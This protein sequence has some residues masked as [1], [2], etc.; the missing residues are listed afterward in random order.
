M[1]TLINE[2]TCAKTPAYTKPLVSDL[3]KLADETK[4]APGFPQAD[5]TILGSA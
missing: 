4:G 2:D 1:Q 5:D 3:G